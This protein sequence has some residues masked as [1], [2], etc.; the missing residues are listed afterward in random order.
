MQPNRNLINR[1]D[2]IELEQHKSNF[3]G[4]QISMGEDLT[5][6]TKEFHKFHRRGSGGLGSSFTRQGFKRSEM[7]FLYENKNTSISTASN[8]KVLLVLTRFVGEA[9]F[10]YLIAISSRFGVGFY[11][12]A[13]S[14]HNM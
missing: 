6:L 1:R 10:V 14:L 5:L 9:A 7:A 2:R 12:K 4:D 3:S 13:C 11:R 8:K